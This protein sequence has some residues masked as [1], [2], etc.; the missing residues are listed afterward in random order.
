MHIY[1]GQFLVFNWL[2]V[3]ENYNFDRASC[4]SAITPAGTSAWALVGPTKGAFHATLRTRIWHEFSSRSMCVRGDTRR[5]VASG[6]RYFLRCRAKRIISRRGNI[7]RGETWAT[8]GPV[9]RHNLW[10]WQTSLSLA[11]AF[12]SCIFAKSWLV[13]KLVLEDCF[14]KL[15]MLG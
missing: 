9:Q 7:V 15:Q 3:R 6:Y 11:C 1:R 14:G 13:W 10:L 12:L 4:G 8:G 2:F 5:P